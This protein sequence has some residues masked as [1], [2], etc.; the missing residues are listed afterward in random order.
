[1][2]PAFRA[3][4][5]GWLGDRVSRDALSVSILHQPAAISLSGHI[6]VRAV[7]LMW[8]AR[9][10]SWCNEIGPSPGLI[11]RWIFEFGSGSSEA[12]H[13]AAVLEQTG[14]RF[15]RRSRLAMLQQHRVAR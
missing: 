14:S 7:P 9:M 13:G 8:A 12:R 5:P 10:P 4:V 3:G 11:E 6:P 15:R 2:T 1:R